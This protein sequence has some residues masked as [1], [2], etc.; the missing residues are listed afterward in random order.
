MNDFKLLMYDKMLLKF[1]IIKIKKLVFE[2]K[3]N[4]DILI[5]NV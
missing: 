2:K 4:C 3:F 1:F 5:I